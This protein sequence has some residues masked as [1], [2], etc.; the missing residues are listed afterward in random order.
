MSHDSSQEQ[1][2]TQ[3]VTT[4][5]DGSVS[6][7]THFTLQDEG[8][9]VRDD[10]VEAFDD[11]LGA[12]GK[13]VFHAMDP[14]RILP[15]TQGGPPVWSVGMVEISEPRPYLLLVT[16]GFSHTLSPGSIRQGIH[17]EYSLAVPVGQPITPWAD[18][19]LRHITRYVLSSQKDLRPGDIMPAFC[20][21]TCWPFQAEHHSNMPE[22]E[23]SAITI[24]PDPVL[25]RIVTPHGEI[26]VRRIFGVHDDECDRIMTWNGA[27]FLEEYTSID[28]A[29]LTDLERPSAMAQQGFVDT[30]NERAHKEGSIVPAIQ[31][32]IFWYPEDGALI[33]E[34]PGGAEAQKLLDAFHG[35]ISFGERLMVIPRQNCP[36]LH[37][38]PPRE[39]DMILNERGLFISGNLEDSMLKDLV[40]LINPDESGSVV[41]LDLS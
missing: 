22:T 24:G 23:L 37:F 30:V 16:Y 3:E 11:A 20:P 19:L 27:S 17:H 2:P 6:V 36:P 29:L 8:R 41:R 13:D 12:L 15:F 1:K 9:P 4:H 38:N 10:V 33:M 34:F 32:D 21:I 14:T 26:E 31:S 18:A 7:T 39:F 40:A 25:P 28:P 35:R 5:E